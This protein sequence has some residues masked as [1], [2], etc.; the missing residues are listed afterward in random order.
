MR[1]IE[2]HEL[3]AIRDNRNHW[4]VSPEDADRWAIAQWAPTEQRPQ[5]MPTF[6]HPD[7]TS[8]LAVAH[9]E[10]AQLRERLADRDAVIADLRE[11]REKWRQQAT[12]L[13]EDKRP[14][15]FFRK[16]LGR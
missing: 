6:A 5:E 1:A 8:E 13:L 16:L 12:A 9:A 11:D 10:N 7:L 15:G 3:E 14:Q 2:R 4:K